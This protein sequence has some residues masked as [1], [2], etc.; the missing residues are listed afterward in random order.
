[1]ATTVRNDEPMTI[2][3]RPPLKTVLASAAICQWRLV[4]TD[5][6][7]WLAVLACIACMAYAA[8]RGQKHVRHRRQALDEAFRAETA[9]VNALRATLG[10]IE[11]GE[12][13]P[14]AAPYRDPRNAIYVGRGQGSAVAH[15]PDA[16]LAAAAVGL[17]D[18]YPQVIVV[19][20]ASKDT[21]LFA[22]EIANPLHSLSGTFDMAFVVACLLPLM[23]LAVGYDVVSVE[24]ERGT[25]AMTAATSA[26][27]A[28][29]L[30]G[31][32]LIRTG[33]VAIA[34]VAAFWLFL[35]ASGG[36]SLVDRLPAA[37]GMTLTILLT[38]LFW[39]AVCLFVN[40]LGRDSATNA[41]IL[42]LVWVVLVVVGPA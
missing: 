36:G 14:P 7:W 35:V 23:I 27:L 15:L 16:P 10:K 28:P 38:W 34:A 25:L 33:G 22:D 12:M 3:S 1:M 20:A 39:A 8:S 41:A 17:S 37:L 13:P 5:P 31:K 2:F 19:S 24:R 32:T 42:I 11:R 4:R 40:S 21:F 18:I 6:A 30:A 29:V 9:R 26:P